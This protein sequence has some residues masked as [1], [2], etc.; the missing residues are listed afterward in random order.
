LAIGTGRL[1][2]PRS[3][4]IANDIWADTRDAMVS[5]KEDFRAYAP[6]SWVAPTV[7]RLL[8]SLPSEHLIGLSSVVLTESGMTGRAKIRRRAGRKHSP[9]E[10]L[11][12]YRPTWRGELP[13]IYLVVDNIV[14]QNPLP[15]QIAR[16][17][18]LAKV[19]FH[20]VGHHLNAKAGLISRTEE[21]SAEA[22][23]RKL[24][25][26][27]FQ[28]RYRFVKPLSPLLKLLLTI[29]R[30]RNARK[31]AKRLTPIKR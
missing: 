28:R 31:S 4:L 11:G 2:H 19:L 21:S 12:F 29:I 22:W 8:D 17:F 18:A 27:H 5:V 16:D 15:L 1:L 24:W 25:P 10:R 26:I 3:G 6:P 13:C 30:A 20:E 14:A 23:S 9:S 7:R